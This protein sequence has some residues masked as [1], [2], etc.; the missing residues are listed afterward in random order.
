[1]IVCRGPSVMLRYWN[2]PEATAEALRGGWFHTGDMGYRDSR[3]YLHITD[4]R[5]DMIIT[6]GE[7]VYPRE[8]EAALIEHP[9]V[10]DVAVVG[11]P[12]PKWGQVVTAV[13]AGQAPSDAELDAWARQRLAGY[14]VPRRWV[15]LAELPRNVTGK[16]LKH[17]LRAQLAK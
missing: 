15:R 5:N 3:G 14:K 16:V 7:N 11:L 8:V 1:E 4:R 13:L 17:R 2:R 6:G 10:A 9:D 12:D